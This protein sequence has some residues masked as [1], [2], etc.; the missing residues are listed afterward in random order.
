MEIPKLDRTA[1]SVTSIDENTRDE[2]AY[3]LAKS[4]QERL[5]AVEIM[6]QILYGYDPFTTRL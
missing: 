6:R 2:K 4:P 3:W 5:Q 1:F